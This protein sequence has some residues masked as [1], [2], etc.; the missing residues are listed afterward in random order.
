MELDEATVSGS[1]LRERQKEAT[2]RE[3][4]SAALR[5]FDRDGYAGTSVDDIAHAAGVSRSTLFRYFR[6]KEAIVAGETDD[7][8]RLFL[9]ILEER[10]AEESRLRA[11]EETLVSFADMQRSDDHRPELQLVQRIIA[12][13]PSLSA[14]QAALTAQWREDVACVLARRGGRRDPDLEDSLASAILGQMIEQMNAEWQ[15]SEGVPASQLIR[16]YFATLRRL[17]AQ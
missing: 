8:A 1:S 3:L 9:R 15:T 11:L 7:R 6:S 12:S 13:D 5:L 16:N 4:R 17:L 14:A 2:R 10:P